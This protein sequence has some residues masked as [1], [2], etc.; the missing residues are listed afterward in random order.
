MNSPCRQREF[1]G[2]IG[3]LNLKLSGLP[4]GFGDDEEDITDCHALELM[5]NDAQ[6]TT[7][8]DTFTGAVSLMGGV[9]AQTIRENSSRGF[10]SQG[11]IRLNSSHVT[12]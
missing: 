10:Y 3:S 6:Q 11:C 2:R 9:E 8:P 5:E 4:N 12:R 1:P 7:D